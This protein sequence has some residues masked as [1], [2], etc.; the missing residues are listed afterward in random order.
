[1]KYLHKLC[2]L[3]SLAFLLLAIV[4]MMLNPTASGYELSLYAAYPVYFFVL[5]ILAYVISTLS[6]LYCV[7]YG[8]V[9][10]LTSVNVFVIMAI[11]FILLFQPYIRG[12]ALF[13]REDAMTH[14]GYVKDILLTS[15]TGSNNFY[16]FIHL[17]TVSLQLLSNLD[18]MFLREFLPFLFFLLYV[19]F[20]YLIVSSMIRDA[21]FGL[22]S[23]LFASVP[24]MS[25]CLINFT[26]SGTLFFLIPF[27]L[28]VL[29]KYLG[30]FS[31][32]MCLLLLVL[33]LAVP[34]M[35]P[36]FSFVLILVS[37]VITTI[38]HLFK[39]QT[40]TATTIGGSLPA[41]ASIIFMLFLTWFINFRQFNTYV[42]LIISFILV[43]L[44]GPSVGGL[45]SG[46][47][48]SP[49]AT[50]SLL[51]SKSQIAF[52]DSLRIIL[53]IY[54]P[55]MVYALLGLLSL[56]ALSY[57]FY[58]TKKYDPHVL[59]FMSLFGVLSVFT[60]ILIVMPVLVT[61]NRILKYVL[62][63]AVILTGVGFFYLANKP[64]AKKTLVVSFIAI[65]LSLLMLVSM[66]NLY[67]SPILYS[68]NYQVSHM[69][70]AG[71]GWF[72]S[73]GNTN[74]PPVYLFYTFGRFA[75]EIQGCEQSQLKNYMYSTSSLNRLPPDHF[76]YHKKPYLR[77][78]YHNE[79]YLFLN[80][81]TRQYY[82]QLWPN[83]NRYNAGDFYMIERDVS[84]SSICT[85][86]ELDIYYLSGQ[87]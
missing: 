2:V 30:K 68:Y 67:P 35:H 63:F 43:R 33:V 38:R 85:N 49:I 23:L 22:L 81:L 86:G 82:L 72:L 71:A 17:E 27:I 62:M 74:I 11:N 5:L 60:A 45:S 24:F 80:K 59:S 21:K 4:V 12:Y 36:E 73:H 20:I 46:E 1:M 78:T 65:I 58:K 56:I 37:L 32:A 40:T 57:Y 6:V 34:F 69:E 29:Y 54:G 18:I 10:K 15:H 26:S 55:M 53:T 13:Q 51:V 79:R 16:P 83:I 70:L 75:N 77:D 64:N 87:Y 61:Y 76:N 8:K 52:I 14:L 7:F 19:F 39:S 42:L 31:I 47:V 25:D 3:L 48:I 66:F 44:G 50:Y 41:I 9:N 28:Y 84:L